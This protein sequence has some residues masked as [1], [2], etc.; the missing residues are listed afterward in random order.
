MVYNQWACDAF[1][2]QLPCS[3]HPPRSYYTYNVLRESISSEIKFNRKLKM[4]ILLSLDFK[5]R[6]S[7]AIIGSNMLY[8]NYIL[9]E[10]MRACIYIYIYTYVWV[11]CVRTIL[12][13]VIVRNINII[14]YFPFNIDVFI[15]V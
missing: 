15:T 12:K 11:L 1:S 13:K 7:N 14:Y 4:T 9:Y 10:F 3:L 6:I 2:N 8:S 5:T